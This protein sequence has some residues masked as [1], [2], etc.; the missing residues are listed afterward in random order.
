MTANDKIARRK[1]SL[2]ELA[3][4]LAMSAAIYQQTFVDTYTNTSLDHLVGAGEQ[5]RQH[6]AS[7]AAASSWRM[8]G[9]GRSE[10]WDELLLSASG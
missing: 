8:S 6:H 5:R 1:L 9:A 4:D 2:L 10:V 3:S 7:S